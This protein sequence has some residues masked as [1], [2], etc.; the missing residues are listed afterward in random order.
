MKARSMWNHRVVVLVASLLAAA[1]ATTGAHGAATPH[2]GPEGSI[3]SPGK[4]T[5][6][7]RAQ[8]VAVT[9]GDTLRVRA[10]SGRG[11]SVRLIGVDAPDPKRP[12]AAEECGWR[13][14]RDRMVRLA[15]ARGAD[16]DG[17]R[18][19]DV[20]LGRGRRVR[21]IRDASQPALDRD[22]RMLAYARTMGG[23]NLSQ[24]QIR[25]GWGRVYA[26]AGKPFRLMRRF[27]AVQAAAKRARRG[28]WG[29]CGG[30]PRSPAGPTGPGGPAGTP[31]LVN[32][33]TF[34]VIAAAGDIAC[35]PADPNYNA[36][37]G[38]STACR[39]LATSELLTGGRLARVLTL[40]DNQYED[41]TLL[42]FQSSYQPSWGRVKGITSPSLGNHEYATANAAG[43][44]D[45]FNGTGVEA[46][47]AGQRG[48]GYY[49]FDVGSWHLIALNSNCSQVGGC[50]A[51]S[52]QEQW[53][54]ADLAANPTSCALAFWHHPRFSSG[55][56]GDESAMTA[57]W[58][59]L[60][61]GGA[62]VV[63]SGHDHDYERFAPQ[64]ATGNADAARGIREFVVGTGGKTLYPMF[65]AKPNSE[66]RNFDTYGVLELALRPAGFDWRFSPAVGSFIDSGSSACH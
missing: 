27:K 60:Y 10:A 56:H 5:R 35:D 31:P 46:G 18:L 11:L 9:G 24:A 59:A 8:I 39:Q 34:P 20:G 16:R 49:S 1:T 58:Q 50:G 7:I 15:F 14:A 40:G 23:P 37:A 6:A 44:F 66:V 4:R 55:I 32:V 2:S 63:L 54:R 51:G 42:K 61:D 48:K 25:A 65:A 45:Y 62:D 38:T 28:V 3:P 30:R 53:L 21:L 57:I 29:G 64:D 47:P 19:L 43:H 12:G 41:A 52:T 36:G 26:V 17:D 33:G 22:G 13:N